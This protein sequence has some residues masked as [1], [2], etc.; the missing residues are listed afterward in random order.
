MTEEEYLEKT[1]N[2]QIKWYSQKSGINQKKYKVTQLVKIALA[3]SIPV[4]AIWGDWSLSKYVVGIIGAL[5]AFIESYV[6]VYN[7]KDLWVKYRMTSETLKHHKNLFLTKTS[8]YDVEKSFNLFVKNTQD[9]MIAE[10]VMWVE[11]NS[12]NEE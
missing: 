5:I 12:Q 11:I 7:F 1:V 10:N 3:V 8:P 4:I 2:N 6:K 9:I